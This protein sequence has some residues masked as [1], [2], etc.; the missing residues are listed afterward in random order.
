MEPKVLFVKMNSKTPY[1][2][3]DAMLRK[4][5]ELQNF[6]TNIFNF[7]VFKFITTHINQIFIS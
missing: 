2:L 1:C 7:S 5:N 6:P 3:Y 4:K